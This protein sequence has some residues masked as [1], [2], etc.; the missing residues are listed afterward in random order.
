M[1]KYLVEIMYEDRNEW[2]NEIEDF[3]DAVEHASAMSNLKGVSE[4]RI[5]YGD[6][7]ESIWV[8]GEYVGN[9]YDLLDDHIDYYDEVGYNPYMGGYDWDC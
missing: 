4:T 6:E 5:W 7:L 9:G 3:A 1:T 2:S 8:D